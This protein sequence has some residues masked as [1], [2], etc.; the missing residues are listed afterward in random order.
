VSD[1]TTHA[2][3]HAI[4]AGSGHL[5]RDGSLCFNPLR[6]AEDIETI[7]KAVQRAHAGTRQVQLPPLAQNTILRLAMAQAARRY[8]GEERVAPSE[9]AVSPGCEVVFVNTASFHFTNPMNNL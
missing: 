8:E 2:S 6:S 9:F 3:E 4:R 1:N 7:A 5:T